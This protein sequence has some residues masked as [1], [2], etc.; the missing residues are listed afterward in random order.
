VIMDNA[1]HI[2]A[3]P[4][5]KSRKHWGYRRTAGTEERYSRR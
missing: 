5:D 2:P 4:S 3:S 1:E